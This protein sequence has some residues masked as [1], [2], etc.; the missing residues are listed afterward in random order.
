M[1]MRSFIIR[2]QAPIVF[3]LL[4]VFLSACGPTYPKERLAE[5]LVELCRREHGL[6]VKAQVVGT[7]LGVLVPI[8]G[9][10]DELRKRAGSN[11][12]RPPAVQVQGDFERRAFDFQIFA[13]GPFVRVDK[14]EESA[15]DK[16]EPAEPIKKLQRVSVGILRVALSTDAKLEFY[17]LIARDP[18]P[19][20]MDLVFTG[21]I[22][23]SKR[24]QFYAIPVSELQTRSEIFVR[25]QPEAMATQTVQQFLIDL[26]RLPLPQLLSRHTAPSRRFGDLLPKVL[27]AAVALKGREKA[28]LGGEWRVRQVAGDTVLVYVP[29]APVGEPDALLFTVELGETSAALA[30]IE[31]LESGRLPGRL[32][33]LGSP[34]T[35]TDSFHVEA[36]SLPEFLTDQIAKRV[37]AEFKPLDPE[38][39]VDSAAPAGTTEE[40]TRVLAEKAAYVVD[41]YEFTDFEKVAITDGLQGTH[42]EIPAADLPLY[43]RRDAPEM[44]PL[45]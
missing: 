8:P 7:T 19:D 37:L 22:T 33:S 23:D 18:G 12:L 9:L 13:R 5:S 39:E 2:G 24:V 20:Q 30:D 16:E 3:A 1:R 32:Q 43:R 26:G 45:P 21:H 40:V 17:R 10:M 36:I 41:S 35:W 31:L 6:E 44:K 29:M 25:I 11:A 38:A 27:V 42:W 4:A 34:E 28:L 15:S 14:R